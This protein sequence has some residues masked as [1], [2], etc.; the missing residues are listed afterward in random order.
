MTIAALIH[1][2][3][4]NK[5]QNET[6]WSEAKLRSNLNLIADAVLIY[7]KSKTS[8]EQTCEKI[9]S[10]HSGDDELSGTSR[11]SLPKE[12]KMNCFMEV[13]VAGILCNQ[14]PRQAEEIRHHA[15]Q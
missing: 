14:L 2:R 3:K 10:L 8:T 1:A 6:D 5:K 11:E 4:L 7:Q 15:L 9:A 13:H 12:R